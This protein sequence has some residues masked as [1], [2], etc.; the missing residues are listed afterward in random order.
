MPMPIPR[1]PTHRQSPPTPPP[2]GTNP[3]HH[4]TPNHIHHNPNRS[5]TPDH[6]NRPTHSSS[7]RWPTTHTHTRSSS[8]HC[9]PQEHTMKD[10][11]Q[12][13][14][15]AHTITRILE[16]GAQALIEQQSGFPA[17]GTDGGPPSASSDRTGRLATTRADK[18]PE[19]SDQDYDRT[20]QLLTELHDILNRARPPHHTRQHIAATTTQQDDG[21]TSCARVGTW[22]ARTTTNTMCRTCNELV[23][24]IQ[25]QCNIT[26]DQPPSQL[27]DRQRQGRRITTREINQAIHQKKT[28]T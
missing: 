24:R 28:H 14:A 10:L 26:L 2:M 13:T 8:H 7:Q 15:L 19:R 16:A 25:M 6:C 5:H 22:T 12:L 1:R 27:V 4:Q 9:Q 17:G 18:G 21:C 3:T 23:L 20:L 11:D